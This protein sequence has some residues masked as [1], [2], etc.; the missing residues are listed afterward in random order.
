[1][2]ATSSHPAQTIYIVSGSV[3]DG[4]GSDVG[5]TEDTGGGVDGAAVGGG[6][7]AVVGAG[8]PAPGSPPESVV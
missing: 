7:A 3:G 8:V 5:G 2:S 6:G 1:M 4:V